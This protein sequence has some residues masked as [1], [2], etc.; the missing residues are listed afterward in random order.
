MSSTWMQTITEHFQAMRR[1]HPDE[2]FM[3][4]FDL[5][6][7]IL[8]V[9]YLIHHLLTDYDRINGTSYFNTLVVSDI[10]TQDKELHDLL[11]RYNVEPGRISQVVEWYQCQK[12]SSTVPGNAY[13]TFSGS[14]EVIRWFQIQPDVAVGL[15]VEEPVDSREAVLRVL[16]AIG[17]P[18]R[19]Q[20]SDELLYLLAYDGIQSTHN[21]GINSIRYFESRGYQVIAVINS[22]PDEL[23]TLF[24]LADEREDLLLVHAD[25][26]SQPNPKPLPGKI[27]RGSTYDVTDL[28][29]EHLLPGQVD[30]VWH[31]INDLP[32]LRQFLGSNIKWGECDIHLETTSNELVL[33]HDSLSTQSK[34]DFER[35]TLATLMSR[36]KESNRSIKL[37]FKQGGKVVD[38]SLE[39]INHYGFTENQL[40][41]NGNVERLEE[42]GFR[43]LAALY[44]NAI[45]QAPIDSLSPL[46]ENN[47]Q[48]VHDTLRKFQNSGMNRF[49]LHWR[50]NNLHRF[51]DYMDKWALEVNIYGVNDLT[52]FL[53]AV[54]YL[55]R[56]V[57]SDFNFPKWYYYGRG[58]GENREYYEYDLRKAQ[59]KD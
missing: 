35:F 8:D 38:Q 20:F 43:K 49:S 6:N 25:L 48:K 42:S 21:K 33:H 4:I 57:T 52:T 15:S 12:W 5:E 47:P 34:Y 23:E 37:D 29:P 44:P 45:L 59:N 53:Q 40:W 56:S 58:S 55:P 31:G 7:V 30:L 51:L 22:D 17:K 32:N 11:F 19:V 26:G 3:I 28:I 41:F 50:V 14:M 39:L 10:H 2:K 9:R 27:L 54:L 16:N 36:M 18:H 24:Q 1:K 46:I 13:H